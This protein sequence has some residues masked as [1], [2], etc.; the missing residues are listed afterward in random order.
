[1]FRV[2]WFRFRATFGRR[3]S[4]YL[5]LV[6]LIGLVGGL[7]MGVVAG[8]RRTQSSYSA[9][10]KSTN[11]SDLSMFGA[12]P[13]E[14]RTLSNKIAQLP[15]IRRAESYAVPIAGPI[16]PDGAP[17]PAAV[18][19]I[20]LGSIDGLGFDQDRVS[21]IQGRVADPVRADEVMV[22]VGAA[23]AFHVHAGDRML[24]GV[25][26]TDQYDAPGFG[27]AKV[28]PIRRVDVTVV[29]IVE[30]NNNVVQDDVDAFG[31][32]GGNI[33]FTPAFTRPITKCCNSDLVSGFRLAGGAR[34]VSVVEGEIERALPKGSA[35][36]VHVTSVFAASAERAIK[37]ESIAL[38]VFG[39]IAAIAALLL[40]V[41]MIGRQLQLD[42]D[43][44]D[45]L[46][47]IGAGPAM[48]TAD[49]LI[50]VIGAVV[51]GSVLALAVAVGLSPLAPIGAARRVYPT[52]G[53]AFDWTVLGVGLMVLIFVSSA[54]AFVL[55]W[56]R[57][58]H[59]TQRHE[60]ST[61]RGTAI[62]RGVAGA[63]LP[64]A[65]VAGTRFAI[66][67][68][69]GRNAAPV[70]SA[71]LGAVIAI[72]VVT[73]TLTFGASLH[74]L[75]SRPALYGWNWD[76]E[77]LTGGGGGN[78]ALQDAHDVLDHDPDVAAWAGVNFDSL[79]IDG[80]TVP[81]LGGR[82]NDSVAPPILTGHGLQAADQIVLGATSLA[83]LHK[84]LG[85]TVDAS[86]GPSRSTRLRIV[87]TAT[88]PAIGP[89]G[90]LH[91]SMGTGA[92][93]SYQLLPADVRNSGS[94]DGSTAFEPSAIFVRM[95]RGVNATA[96]LATLR[97]RVSAKAA[98]KATKGTAAGKDETVSVVSVQRPAEI[99]NYRSMGST[100]ALLGGALAVAAIAALALTLIAS[101]RRRRRDLALLKTLGFTHRQLAA[102]VAWQSTIAVGI[103]I[104]VGVPLGIVV[105]RSLWELFA[106]ELH[107]VARPSVPVPT[108]LLV[109]AGALV[110][111][112][113]V[114][115]LPGRFAARTPAALALHGE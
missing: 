73:G 38:G 104:V 63:G 93:V 112:N 83:Q 107:V 14:N 3:W 97:R 76:C 41:Q 78:I 45:A 69:R 96:S 68:G 21:A 54:A 59:R 72:V 105:G 95:R 1:M 91:L 50:G 8:A 110:L 103:G 114:A 2:A 102:A 10:L 60:R 55:A 47:A 58:P 98:A 65:A 86:Y 16:A 22:T 31:E 15:G 19:A 61:R 11:P 115:A 87:G 30:F 17:T 42:A 77:I 48:T 40:A 89:A 49:G 71:I 34:A 57:A 18:N 43:H 32:G 70:R 7:A 85:D 79:R 94:R 51:I 80:E 37:P 33:I 29:G 99:V 25:F 106:H 101:V 84:H 88:M 9:F 92:L 66:E 109:A 90:Q 26:T 39:A 44:L 81:I 62:V 100:P 13:N 5:A 24:I 111:A 113:V 27:T 108:I 23:R 46:R 20:P 75:V 67:S 52:R 35:Y 56:R 82:P 6:L 74:T 53:L 28:Q 36:Y 4:G 12:L 64:V